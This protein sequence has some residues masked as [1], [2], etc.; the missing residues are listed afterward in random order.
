MC[1]LL[2]RGPQTTGELATRAFRLYEFS[3]LEEVESTLNSLISRE[4]DPLVMR[5]PRQAWSERSALRASAVGEN[6]RSK[7]SADA[8]SATA[9][10]QTEVA[11]RSERVEKLEHEVVKY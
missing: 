2:L 1:V 7:L 5:L 11:T 3:G 10:R 4:P 8:T 6:Q 9:G